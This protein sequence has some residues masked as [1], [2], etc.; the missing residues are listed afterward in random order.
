M[1]IAHECPI[2][3]FSLV[4]SLT[5]YDY[6][7]AHLF[8]ENTLYRNQFYKSKDKGREI[9]LD[10]SIFELGTAFDSNKYHNIINDLQP[11][12][13]IIPDVLE[14][15]SGT[16]QSMDNW[17]LDFGDYVPTTI[18]KIG[19]VQGKN[20]EE[21]CQCYRH[22]VDKGCDKIGISFDYSY[23]ENLYPQES[24]RFVSWMK[25]RR[26]FILKLVSEDF[27]NYEIPLHLLGCSLPQEFSFYKNFSFIDSLDTSNP[28]VWGISKTP[29]P[30][31][32]EDVDTKITQKLFTMIDMKVDYSSKT[33]I[34]SNIRK[35][36]ESCTLKID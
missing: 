28:V 36:R 35:F 3:I 5:D 22:L 29:Y 13:Y 4:E 33:I 19:V 16:I 8:D 24:N 15:C 18:K 20:Y 2:S 30:L 14:D 9:I 1:K 7:L 27:Y 21:L 23:Y 11:D 10:N 25:G 17:M 32:L 34:E 31:D 6:C 26:D 12:W